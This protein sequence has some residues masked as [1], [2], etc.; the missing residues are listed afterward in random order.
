[1]QRST[2]YKILISLWI[3]AFVLGTSFWIYSYYFKKKARC[4]N[5]I[6]TIHDSENNKLIDENMVRATLQKHFSEGFEGKAIATIPMSKIEQVLA[7]IQQADDIKVY[8]D[9]LN[10]L[11]IDVSQA[12]P[13]FRVINKN[14][15]GFYVSKNCKRFPL[16]HKFTV[17]VPIAVGNISAEVSNGKTDSILMQRICGIVRYTSE[18]DFWRIATDQ[19]V[20]ND[21]HEIEIVPNI[22]QMSIVVGDDNNIEDKLEK[23]MVFM[24]EGL[25]KVGWN[26]YEKIDVRFNNQIVCKKK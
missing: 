26:K 18:D 22:G 15:V 24:R 21:E 25:N 16:S 10:N 5:V 8:A 20:V 1:M 23:A 19:I 12:Q 4:R 9:V 2:K 14:G 3:L 13:M 6:V 17:R 7:T 11:Q